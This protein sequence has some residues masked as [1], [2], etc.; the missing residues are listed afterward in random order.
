MRGAYLR[1]GTPFFDIYVRSISLHKL[2]SSR[3]RICPTIV[4][5]IHII[6]RWISPQSCRTLCQV[7]SGSINKRTKPLIIH[8]PPFKF[9]PSLQIT[10]GS[11]HR[12]FE[13]DIDVFVMAGFSF[14]DLVIDAKGIVLFQRLFPPIPSFSVQRAQSEFVKVC[15][16]APVGYPDCLQTSSWVFLGVVGC[17]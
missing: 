8:N 3:I 16:R 1:I 10:R 4:R 5:S 15:D 6:R 17:T 7:T 9:I 12:R 11:H 2:P 13:V 14:V